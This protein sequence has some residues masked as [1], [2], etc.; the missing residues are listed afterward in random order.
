MSGYLPGLYNLSGNSSS[1]E[2]CV[3]GRDQAASAAGKVTNVFHYNQRV[4]GIAQSVQVSETAG[5][6][7]YRPAAASSPILA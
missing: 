2:I 4:N 1:C 5:R 3:P 6:V 7:P